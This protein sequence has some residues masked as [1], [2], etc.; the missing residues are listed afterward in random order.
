VPGL[1]GL[2][3]HLAG[4]ASRLS[5]LAAEGPPYWGYAWAGGLALA[6]H[7]AAQP[8]LAAG[9]EAVDLGAGGG[10]VTLAAARAGARVLAAE[11]DPMGRAALRANLALNGLRARV[12]GRDLTAGPGLGGRLI[13]AGDVFYEPALA[14]RVLAWLE[15]CRAAGARVLVGDPFRAPLPLERLRLLSRETLPDPGAARPVPAGVFELLQ[16]GGTSKRRGV[17]A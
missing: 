17:G 10:V 2:R 16:P 12:T 6:R 13:L 3:L 1:P 5:E 11:T 14:A 7:V 15:R 4:P 8:G 9:R